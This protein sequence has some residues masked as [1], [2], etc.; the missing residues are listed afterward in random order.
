MSPR[1]YISVLSSRPNSDSEGSSVLCFVFNGS[2]AASLSLIL[3]FGSRSGESSRH[4]ESRHRFRTRTRTIQ[5]H[6]CPWGQS[7]DLTADYVLVLTHNPIIFKHNQLHPTSQRNENVLL[8]RAVIVCCCGMEIHVTLSCD[9]LCVA[10]C[11]TMCSEF[12]KDTV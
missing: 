6:T 11:L 5:D 10:S 9:A 8:H 7:P 4:R 3:E 1:R 12:H 2:P